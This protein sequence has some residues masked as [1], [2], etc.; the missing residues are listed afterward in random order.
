MRVRP[1][2]ASDRP[3][4]PPRPTVHAV[5]DALVRVYD[6]APDTNDASDMYAL[7]IDGV[8]ILFRLVAE[9]ADGETE[10]SVYV[11]LEN[12][13]HPKGTALMADINGN[14]SDYR[15]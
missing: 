10:P 12:T 3:V 7:E 11:Y 2:G 14:A 5:R 13:G 15:F 8:K 4:T 6:A 1:P 9:D